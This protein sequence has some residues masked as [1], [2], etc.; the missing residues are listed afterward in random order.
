MSV[1]EMRL[2]GWTLPPVGAA[3]NVGMATVRAA[4]PEPGQCADLMRKFRG[5]EEAPLKTADHEL[6]HYGTEGEVWTEWSWRR[7]PCL[8]DSLFQGTYLGRAPWR[9]ASLSRAA[10]TRSTSGKQPGMSPTLSR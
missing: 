3:V 4:I 5:Q 7:A 1:E 9:T 8:T 6:H 2:L 10:G